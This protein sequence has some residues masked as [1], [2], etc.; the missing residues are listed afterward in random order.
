MVGQ[1]R[2]CDVAVT[3]T[4]DRASYHAVD[5]ALG[6][7]DLAGEDLKAASDG[8][9]GMDARPFLLVSDHVFSLGGTH[10]TPDGTRCS[11]KDAFT[12][13]TGWARAQQPFNPHY[14]AGGLIE[15]KPPQFW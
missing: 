14:T 12:F 7:Y 10:P 13:G 5:R 3:G 11:R 8:E 9:G 1:C 15:G 2:D 4:S 6:C